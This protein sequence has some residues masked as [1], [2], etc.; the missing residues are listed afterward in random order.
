MDYLVDMYSFTDLVF[1]STLSGSPYHLTVDLARDLHMIK[2]K[3][4]S[5]DPLK[6]YTSD[7]AFQIG[8]LVADCLP[9][10]LQTLLISLS[11]F[12]MLTLA[13]QPP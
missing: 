6:Q 12:V 7:F 13:T 2:E 9:A 10:H 11:S 3:S 4:T 1:N 5:A 8:H